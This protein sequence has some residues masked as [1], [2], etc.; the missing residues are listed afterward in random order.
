MWSKELKCGWFTYLTAVRCNQDTLENY[1]SQHPLPTA[2]VTVN[3]TSKER[4]IRGY[5]EQ[6]VHSG[7]VIWKYLEVRM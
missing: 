6:S 2:D 3:I 7:Q 1:F 5:K 4:N